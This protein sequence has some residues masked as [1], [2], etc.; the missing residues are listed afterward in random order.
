MAYTVYEG[1]TG[2]DAILEKISAFALASG[3]TILENC[4]DDLAIDGSGSY[5][6]KRLCIKNAV[7]TVFGSFRTATG[8]KIFE[9]QANEGNAH[10]IGLIAST[11]HTN[12]PPSGFWYDQPNVTK[13]YGTQ[14]AIGVG[15]PVNPSGTYTLYCNVVKKPA[16]MLVFSLTDGTVFQHLALGYLEK[17]GNWDGGLIVSGSRNS[18][19]MFTA[20]PTFD[21]TTIETETTPLFSMAQNANTFLRIDMDNAPNRSQPVLW[22]SAG[23]NDASA[24]SHCY[25]GKQM[26]LPVKTREVSDAAW[27][28]FIPD[29]RKLMSES[30][31]DTG[32]NVN[33][34]NCITVNMNLVCYVIRDP[35]ALRNF[36]PVGYVPGIYFISL[37]NV[38]PGQTYEISYPTSGALHQVFPYTRR[39]GIY[40]MDGFS[41]KQ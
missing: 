13:E 32:K 41:V 29:Y 10:G 12:K 38:A 14:Q 11:A 24:F 20:S 3:W 19:H 8:K 9:T 5:D 39:R 33:T 2:P 21:A 28:A 1:L 35:D 16:D 6:G 22:A 4:L 27:N 31:L 40:G 30:P 15:V 17:V 7:G 25:T 26:A 34:L 23:A 36:S 37:R 18:Y